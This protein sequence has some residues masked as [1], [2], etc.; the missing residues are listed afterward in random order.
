MCLRKIGVKHIKGLRLVSDLYNRIEALCKAH[1][2][3]ITTM[4]KESGVSRASLSDLKMGR[5]KGLNAE[6]LSKIADYFDVSV[7]YL[8]GNDQKQK[9]PAKSES[10]S[11]E[12]AMVAL[13]GG[14]GEV[15]QAMWEEAENYIDFIIERERKKSENGGQPPKAGGG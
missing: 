12:D 2:I 6:T 13:F 10:I 9:A 11:K 8:L 15:S 4:C 5:K 7:D 3:N 14:R 1:K